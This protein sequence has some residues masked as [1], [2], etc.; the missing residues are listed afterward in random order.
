M[1]INLVHP[2]ISYLLYFV[3]ASS[4][5]SWASEYIKNKNNKVII[6]FAIIY[7]L[8]LVGISIINSIFLIFIFS[9]GFIINYDFAINILWIGL[10]IY[11]AINFIKIFDE[12]YEKNY[13]L[14]ILPK[15]AILGPLII[16]FTIFYIIYYGDKIYK[17]SPHCQNTEDPKIKFCKYSNGTYTGEMKAFRRHGQGE[18]IWDSGK[19]YK[20]EWK[21]GKKLNQ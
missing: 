5:I 17:L 8:S 15:I 3:I 20:G 7:Y 19:T 12:I 2:W 21:N 6:S 11:L 1:N 4:L 13:F 16:S 9:A 10:F 18:Y 14:R